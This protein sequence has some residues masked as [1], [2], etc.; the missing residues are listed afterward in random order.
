MSLPI[1]Q[2]NAKRGDVTLDAVYCDTREKDCPQN[3]SMVQDLLVKS[4]VDCVRRH[5]AH[6]QQKVFNSGLPPTFS[7]PERSSG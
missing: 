2:R 1:L 7:V 6:A 4:F 5:R 3:K